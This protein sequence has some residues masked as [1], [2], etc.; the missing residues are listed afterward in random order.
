MVAPTIQFPRVVDVDALRVCVRPVTPDDRERIV[1]GLRSM[2]V[3][4]SY[5]RFFTPHFYPSEETL[6]YLTHVDGD[7]H[8]ALGAVDCTRE[9][10]PGIGAARYVRL[11]EQPSVA[12]AA[13]VVIDAYQQRGIGSILIAALSRYAAGHGVERFRG[14]V[15]AENRD[16]LAYLRALG[17]G[18]EQVYG[19]VIQLDVPVYGRAAALPDGPETER[20][21]WAWHVLDAARIG[22]CD[23]ATADG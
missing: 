1:E 18:N 16:F 9:G 12:E 6:H 3:E 11:S 7:Q 23:G 20:A 4:T 13:V 10:E 19:G 17:G 2:S 22:D 21:R 8:V 5:R 14:F 15:L